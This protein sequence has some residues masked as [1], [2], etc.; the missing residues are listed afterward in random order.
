MAQALHNRERGAII[1]PFQL[2][3]QMSSEEGIW[4]IRIGMSL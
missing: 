4:I 2:P 3:R 1:E